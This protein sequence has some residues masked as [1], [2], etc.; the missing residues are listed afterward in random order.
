MLDFGTGTKKEIREAIAKAQSL[1]EDRVIKVF[2][3]GSDEYKK[4]EA[5]A[6]LL[7]WLTGKQCYV[8]ET[9][10]DYGQGWKWTTVLQKDPSWGSVQLF[11]PKAQQMVI[12]AKTGKDLGEACDHALKPIGTSYFNGEPEPK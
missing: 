11:T 6:N 5:A 4:L 2:S 3:P 1:T 9:Y 10:Y 8:G 7:T 12:D